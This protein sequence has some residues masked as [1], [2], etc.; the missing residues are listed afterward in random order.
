VCVCVDK[1]TPS[2]PLHNPYAHLRLTH[3]ELRRIKRIKK[4][5]F[6]QIVCLV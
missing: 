3:L 2:F 4:H 5:L 6:A 1:V